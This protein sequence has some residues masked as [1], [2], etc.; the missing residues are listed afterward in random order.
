[1]VIMLILVGLVLGG[2]FGFQVFKGIMIARFF[3]H[4]TEPPQTVSTTTAKE[5]LWQ[6][7][8]QAVGSLTARHGTNVA[9]EV[10]GIVAN[11][12]FKSGQQ[13]KAGDLLVELDSE[14]DRARLKS[15]QAMEVL[16]EKTYA[17]SRHLYRIKALSKAQLDSASA[18]LDS[19]RAQ[20]TQERA[21]LDQKFIRAPF[22]G[23]LGISAVSLGQYV[24]PGTKLVALQ[25]LDPIYVDF[26]VPQKSVH[27]LNV[28]QTV[29]VKSD[30]LRGQ[31][32]N[33]EITAIEPEVSISTRNVKVRA[34]V[35]NPKRL[36]LPGMFVTVTIKLGKPQSHVTLPQTSIA[37]NPY[38]N[39]VYTVQQEGVGKN[40]KPRLVAHQKFVV[41]GDTR[42][43][44]VAV[45]SGLKPGEVVV[46]A[47]QLKLHNGTPVDINN[48]VQ[49]TDNPAP[50]PKDE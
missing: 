35:P 49:P 39:I 36:L 5:S 37:Y 17:R 47:G 6:P 8:I 2:V 14:V 22:S 10:P 29:Q 45:L 1:M 13:V 4:R 50:T 44:Q 30:A 27:A 25:A 24:N 38:G 48:A 7:H 40:G 26:N 16:A 11:I 28:G 33:G 23:R 12:H 20:V 46:T 15:L 34:Q 41:T 42:G 18:Q 19:A 32:F 3:A 9:P 31:I 21:L 43:D